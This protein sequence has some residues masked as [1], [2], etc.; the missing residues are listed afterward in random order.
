VAQAAEAVAA[1]QPKV[2]YPYHYRNQDKSL[3]DIEEFE[4]ILNKMAPDVQVRRADWYPELG[5]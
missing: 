1:F 5:K 4:S 3:S 2:V